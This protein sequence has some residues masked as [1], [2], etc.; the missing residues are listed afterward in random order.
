MDTSRRVYASLA[1]YLA[2]TGVS[3]TVLAAQLGLTQGAISRY[4]SGQ[5]IPRPKFLQKFRRL[6]IPIAAFYEVHDR[7]YATPLPKKPS[8]SRRNA[9]K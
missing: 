3:Q 9:L 5:H 7:Y 1:D 6:G 4:A 8:R 2:V